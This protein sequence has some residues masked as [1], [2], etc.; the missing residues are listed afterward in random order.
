MSHNDSL[1]LKFNDYFTIQEAITPEDINSALSLRYRVFC[2]ERGFETKNDLGVEEDL[3]DDAASHFIIRHNWTNTIVAA[4][5]TIIATYDDDFKFPFEQFA[6]DYVLPTST[7][8]INMME[9]SRL[10]VSKEILA[11]LK[12]SFN[13]DEL[14]MSKLLLPALFSAGIGDAASMGI[15]NF[16]GCMEPKA[17]RFMQMIG[18]VPQIIGDKFEHKGMRVPLFIPIEKSLAGAKSKNAELHQLLTH[19]I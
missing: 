11:E 13:E 1:S 2:E 3:Y 12:P 15:E 14:N 16:V 18:F 7:P 10:S 17:V 6:S 9:L 5:R 8:K 19:R 4:C